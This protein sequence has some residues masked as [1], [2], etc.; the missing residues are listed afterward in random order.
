MARLLLETFYLTLGWVRFKKTWKQ[1]NRNLLTLR[2]TLL[3]KV[4]NANIILD[5]AN[6]LQSAA[7]AAA[8]MV[9]AIDRLSPY[10]GNFINNCEARNS[11]G[12]SL[13]C[14]FKRVESNT[15]ID[16][17]END[18]LGSGLMMT[19]DAGSDSFA[20]LNQNIERLKQTFASDGIGHLNSSLLRPLFGSNL[21]GNNNQLTSSPPTSLSPTSTTDTSIGYG[22][23][24]R[25]SNMNNEALTPPP[26][27]GCYF[28]FLFNLLYKL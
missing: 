14:I 22:S 8:S 27:N 23:L 10:V 6:K 5:D 1:W 3:L 9:Y 25:L 2:F 12:I 13:D 16:L 17:I 28:F 4:L 20:L 15:H 26:D 18:C 11:S 19:T 21:D 7:I 24:T